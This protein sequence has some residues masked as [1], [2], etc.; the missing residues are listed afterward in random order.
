MMAN[1][2]LSHINNNNNQ[3]DTQFV[4]TYFRDHNERFRSS[5]IKIRP[6]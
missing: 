1:R 3:T 4:Q 5:L 2:Q 6:L